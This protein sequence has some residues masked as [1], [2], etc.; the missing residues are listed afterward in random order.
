MPHKD[1]VTPELR[2]ALLKRDKT[3]IGPVIGMEDRCGSQFGSGG[4]IA[5]EIDHVSTSGLGKRGPS[6]MENCVILC[7][8]H[9]RVKTESSKRWRAAIKEYLHEKY[10]Y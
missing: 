10:G 2:F 1:P 9:H 8:W 4:R 6:T 5:L 3:C 7:G